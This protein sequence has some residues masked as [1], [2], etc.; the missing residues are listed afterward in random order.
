MLKK[1]LSVVLAALLIC[2]VFSGC[3]QK[4]E[5]TVIIYSSSEEYRNEYVTERLKQEFPDYYI[6]LI[7]LPN[8]KNAAKVKSEGKN[9]KADIIL[10]METGY[11]T[12]IQDHL[13][14]LSEYDTSNYLEDMK[15][16]GHKYLGW[17]RYSGSI[18]INPKTM[19]EKNL[20]VPE[21]YEDLLNPVYKDL[22]CM[23]NPKASSTGYM[24]LKSLCNAWGEDKAF[25]YFDKL[26]EN[27]YQF[28]SSGSGPV[29]ALVQ[30]EAAIGLGMTFQAVEQINKGVPLEILYF[31]EG[32]PYSTGGMAVIDGRLE[33]KAVKDVFD[34]LANTIVYE[35]KEKYSPEQIF[36]DQVN[37]T[38]NYPQ[39]IPYADMSGLEDLN[40]KTRLLEKWRF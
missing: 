34:F 1:C 3:T 31:E 10:G 4:D 27:I 11:L 9:S 22:I 18:I 36:K 37:S 12:S 5:N 19:K 26:A 28:T 30:G 17:E 35:D 20:P 16:R 32:S 24:F 6:R 25:D 23:P 21:S 33:N 29:N 13:A 40:D 14:D 7:Y 38:P 8:G 2:G 15:S 39:H